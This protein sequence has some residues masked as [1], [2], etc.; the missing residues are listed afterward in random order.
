M[1]EK[2][3]GNLQARGAI[4]MALHDLAGKVAGYLHTP[5]LAAR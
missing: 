2:I 1:D 3:Q 4:N 5:C